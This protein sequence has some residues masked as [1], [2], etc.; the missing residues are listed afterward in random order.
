M[1][2]KIIIVFKGGSCVEIDLSNHLVSFDKNM[3]KVHTLVEEKASLMKTAQDY[4]T[5]PFDMVEAFEL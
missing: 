3:L 2:E 4:L 5:L 1:K